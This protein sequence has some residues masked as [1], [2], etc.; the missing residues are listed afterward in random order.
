[1]SVNRRS[2]AVLISA[3]ALVL[4]PT[5]ALSQSPPSGSPPS[6]DSA[7]AD[8]FF[9]EGK[10]LFEQGRF[11]EACARLALSDAIDPTVST[12]GLL[13]GC[14]EQQGRVATAAREYRATAKRAEA[15]SDSRAAFAKERADAL[16]PSLPKLL[17]RLSNPSPDIEI[18]RNLERMHAEEV[19]VEIA[20]DPGAYEIVARGPKRQEFRMTITAKEGA[21]VVV[22]VPDLK[23]LGVEGA[24]KPAPRPPSTAPLKVTS[25]PTPVRA[26]NTNKTDDSV[27]MSSTRLKAAAVSGGIGLA[28]LGL[29]AMFGISAM[30]QSNDSTIIHATC[31]TPDE[32]SRGRELR[33]GAYGAST[34]ATVS[35][36]VGAA[37]IGVGL[38]L[39]L[40]PS[41]KAAAPDKRSA[42]AVRIA[43]I[44]SRDG[45]GATVVGRF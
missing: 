13:A 11:D 41:E 42:N 3:S 28:G 29:G 26:A 38:V 36:A 27:S 34:A 5:E 18:F 35:F 14:H 37:G 44:A 24:A 17:I 1:V 25:E 43:P 19:G 10:V 39:L 33:E 22:D 15:V 6:G 40:L 45:G 4:S 30:S 21:K 23:A 2:L 7:R 31:K 9:Q 20:V 8:A 16:E 32:C 12:L